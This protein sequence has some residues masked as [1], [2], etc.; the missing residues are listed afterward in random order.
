MIFDVAGEGCSSSS[1]IR[2]CLI[3]RALKP[4]GEAVLFRDVDLI[5]SPN[6]T[7]SSMAPIG[8]I[9]ADR[10]ISFL[11]HLLPSLRVSRIQAFR[12]LTLDLASGGTPSG[13]ILQQLR[14]LLRVFRASPASLKIIIAPKVLTQEL[15]D[16]FT[17]TQP[18]AFIRVTV[19][20]VIS[21]TYGLAPHDHLHQPHDVAMLNRAECRGV[22]PSYYA[23]VQH[24]SAVQYGRSSDPYIYVIA[25]HRLQEWSLSRELAE[26]TDWHGFAV[27][28]GIN[29]DYTLAS[30]AH[31]PDILCLTVDFGS[32][33]IYPASTALTLKL[34]RGISVPSCTETLGFIFAGNR[35]SLP[36]LL[37]LLQDSKWVPSVNEF[38]WDDTRAIRPLCSTKDEPLLDEDGVS[39]HADF[40]AALTS[41]GAMLSMGSGNEFRI[42]CP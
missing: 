17:L 30:I 13:W 40:A 32:D 3:S 2:L 7:D 28:Y 8:S 18:D 24:G 29:N 34:M 1:H 20:V 31:F 41:R 16:L 4:F 22:F 10:S 6:H 21:S 36:D 33:S 38:I 12:N 14:R 23:W 9:A 35:P 19:V 27:M 25:P 5:A 15:F 42:V 37:S 26:M 11:E 39:W